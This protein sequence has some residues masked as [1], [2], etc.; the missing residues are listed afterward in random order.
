MNFVGTVQGAIR[1]QV[2]EIEL[3]LCLCTECFCERLCASSALLHHLYSNLWWAACIHKMVAC[4]SVAVC[5][6]LNFQCFRGV[7]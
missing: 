5:V 7:V 1:S 3:R 2:A 4:S 6:R